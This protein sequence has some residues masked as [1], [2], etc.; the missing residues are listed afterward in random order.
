MVRFTGD[1]GRIDLTAKRSRLLITVAVSDTGAGIGSEHLD[2]I[3]DR[4]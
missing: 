3:F 2:S 4:A 1:G